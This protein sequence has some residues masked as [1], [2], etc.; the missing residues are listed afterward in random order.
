MLKIFLYSLLFTLSPV[1]YSHWE[2]WSDKN[3]NL[4][5]ASTAAMTADWLLTRDL[6]NKYHLGYYEKNL[7]LGKN[8][9][10]DKIDLYFVSLLVGSYFFTNYLSDRNRTI[11][12]TARTI[13]HGGA[14]INNYTIGLRFY[15]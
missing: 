3:K 2:D 14:A 13:S 6:P 8:P 10:T 11:F 7:I 5:I 4:F 12:L 9:S 15:W 1:C